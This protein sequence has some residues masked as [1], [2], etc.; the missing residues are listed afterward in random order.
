MC[1]I[2]NIKFTILVSLLDAF[3]LGHVIQ[4]LGLVGVHVDSKVQSVLKPVQ[5]A[6][7]EINAFT[8]VTA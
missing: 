8:G 2:T 5:R 6:G 1:S 4:C 7:T 3:V